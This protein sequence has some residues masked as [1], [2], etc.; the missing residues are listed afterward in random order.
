M[1]YEY[2]SEYWMRRAEEVRRE[3]KKAEERLQQPKTAVPAKR[4]APETGIEE[5]EPVP[6]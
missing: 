4:A 2:E 5:R 3:M 6:A 1:C